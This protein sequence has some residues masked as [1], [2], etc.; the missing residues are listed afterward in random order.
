MPRGA[1]RGGDEAEQVAPP[2]ARRA[3]SL[4][5]RADVGEEVAFPERRAVDEALQSGDGG[6]RRLEITS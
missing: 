2:R 6:T 1:E 4:Q 3:V 5:V